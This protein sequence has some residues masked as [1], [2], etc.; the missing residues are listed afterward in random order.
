MTPTI[1]ALWATSAWS[2]YPVEVRRCLDRLDV[3]CAHDLL[4]DLSASDSKDGDVLAA[5]AHTYFQEGRYPEAYDTM[6]KAVENGFTDRYEEQ[7][8]YERTLYATANWVQEQQGRF[9]VR[10]RP[11][12]DAMLWPDAMAAVRASDEHIA[13]LLGGSPP[14]NTYVELYPDGR[15]FIG[16]SSLKAEDVYTTGVVGLAKWGKLLVTS[17]RALPRGYAWQDTIAHEYIHLVVAHHTTDRAPVWLQE[18]IAKYLDGR[19]RDGQDRFR[20]TVR[21]QGLLAQAIRKDDLVTF[22]EM[23]PSLAKLPSAER[24]SLAYAQLATLM[25]YCFERGGDGVL[26]RTLPAVGRGMDPKEALATAVGATDFD[27]MISE[28]R[29]WIARQ[30]LVERHLQELPTV[31]DGGDD[32]DLDPVLAERQDLARYVTLGDILREAG[33]VEASLVEYAKAVPDNE[34]PS[35]ILSNRIAQAN[36]QLGKLG[37]AKMALEMSLRD[38]PEFALSH[39][40]LGQVYLKQERHTEARDALLEAVAIHPFDPE[41]HQSLLEAYRALGDEQGVARHEGALRIRRRGGDDVDREPVHTREGEFELPTYDRHVEASGAREAYREKWVGE[42]MPLVAALD[43]NGNPIR[44]SDFAGKVLLLDFWATWCGPCREAMPELAKLHEAHEAD[45]LVV[46]GLTDEPTSRVKP[47]L[48]R[49]PVP[50]RIGIDQ[51]RNTA[52]LFEVASLPTAFVV[53]REGRIV[54]VVVGA[55]ENAYEALTAAVRSALEDT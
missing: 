40:T 38:Y 46:L 16:A 26:L 23:H 35:P 14:G 8:L 22:E 32:M 51:G 15:S 19:W 20:L 50:Y 45:G 4:E 52:D 29:A 49:R 44:S 1:L 53:D 9:V 37:P 7:A 30:P 47:F 25:Q 27:E 41:S 13:P 12:V 39:K 36:L 24:A 21:Q 5:L 11:G 55:G 54:E 10:F 6:V 34:P 48:K 28:W 43:L 3:A 17:P 31:L 2:A 33:E 42:K 18:A